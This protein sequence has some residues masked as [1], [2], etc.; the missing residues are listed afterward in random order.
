MQVSACASGV[1]LILINVG[2]D[3][4]KN[5]LWDKSG[6]LECISLTTYPR[7]RRGSRSPEQ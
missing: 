3:S 1:A 4:G 5:G 2:H 7:I 6:L